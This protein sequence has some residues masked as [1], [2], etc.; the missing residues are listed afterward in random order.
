MSALVTKVRQSHDEWELHLLLEDQTDDETTSDEV[1]I[2]N[3]KHLGFIVVSAAGVSG[4]VVE[5]E[6]S[7]TTGYTGTWKQIG[8]LTTN[9]AT[10]V[11]ADSYAPTDGGFP[12]RYVRARISTV[13]SG[14]G[15]PSVSV[16]L[17]V[18][19]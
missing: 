18:Q 14:G 10:T 12:S 4:G 9:A 3:A 5:L 7:P 15:S 17:V 2:S 6:S 19:R 16:Y 11:F 1:D 8:T 13:I